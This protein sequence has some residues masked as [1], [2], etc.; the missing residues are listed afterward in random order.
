MNFG[1]I[2]E[3]TYGKKRA[4][5]PKSDEAG[6]PRFLFPIQPLK[7]EKTLV[8][9]DSTDTKIMRNDVPIMTGISPVSEIS[10]RALIEKCCA[11]H[12]MIS[13]DRDIKGGKPVIRDSRI[14]VD[15][16]LDRLFV[17][18]SISKVAKL[19][20]PDISEAQIKEAVAY[21]RDFM[22]KACDQSEVDD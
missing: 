15:Y 6:Q 10:I 16:V 18:G 3:S 14:A 2:P 17:H 7:T 1:T 12:P 21:A 19:F 20:A 13:V 5:V 9:S 8:N 22:E 11:E 4:G